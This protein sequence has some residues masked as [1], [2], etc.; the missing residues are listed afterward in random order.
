MLCL[1]TQFYY[2]EASLTIFLFGLSKI[3]KCFCFQHQRARSWHILD[4]AHFSNRQASFWCSYYIFSHHLSRSSDIQNS[5][6]KFA[7]WIAFHSSLPE[8]SKADTIIQ[9]LPYRD[10]VDHI[11]IDPSKHNSL[12]RNN[13]F[14]LLMHVLTAVL[15]H[16]IQEKHAVR[17][18]T[19]LLSDS[20]WNNADVSLTT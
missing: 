7:K 16:S 1:F 2:L 11:A 12:S 8:N 3:I 15:N 9:M 18:G 13:Y 4:F 14:S 10:R 19:V 5:R 17:P 6:S 20:F